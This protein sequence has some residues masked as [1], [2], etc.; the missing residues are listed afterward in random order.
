MG[1]E[2]ADLWRDSSEKSAPVL[3]G[4]K[5]GRKGQAYERSVIDVEGLVARVR[6]ETRTGVDNQQSPMREMAAVGER[7]RE[8]FLFCDAIAS[9]VHCATPARLVLTLL[10]LVP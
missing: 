8:I 4:A 2:C 7:K 3:P 1:E 6:A 10:T 5:G 9:D